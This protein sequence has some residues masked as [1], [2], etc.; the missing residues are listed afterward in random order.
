MFSRNVIEHILFRY[1]LEQE[2]EQRKKLVEME[3]R[4]IFE[5]IAE[6][7]S[8]GAVRFMRK[9]LKASHGLMLKHLQDINKTSGSMWVFE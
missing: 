1:R 7:D 5:C 2:V 8:K 6:K 9:H 3:H 4:R